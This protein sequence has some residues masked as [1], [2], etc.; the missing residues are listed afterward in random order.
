MPKL[1]STGNG[2]RVGEW[3]RVPFGP[4]KVQGLIVEDRGSIGAGGQRLFVVEIPSDPAEPL[5][6]EVPEPEVEAVTRLTPEK[7]ETLRFLTQ[8]GL[9][10]ILRSNTSG[11]RDQPRVW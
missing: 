9:L 10:A 6:I 11:G 4:R 3:V 1:K 2:I 7:G 8:G 5:T